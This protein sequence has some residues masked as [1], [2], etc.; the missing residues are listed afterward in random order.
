VRSRSPCPPASAAPGLIQQHPLIRSTQIYAELFERA[1]Q[2]S[3]EL[4]PNAQ[5]A[6]A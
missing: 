4:T 3:L 6:T 5:D 1:S 2:V